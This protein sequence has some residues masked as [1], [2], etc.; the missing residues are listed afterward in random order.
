MHREYDSS[1]KTTDLAMRPSFCLDEANDRSHLHHTGKIFH[2]ICAYLREHA[3]QGS[4]YSH[5]F[6]FAY[7]A[8]KYK[9]CPD[10][11]GYRYSLALARRLSFDSRPTPRLIVIISAIWFILQSLLHLEMGSLSPMGIPPTNPDGCRHGLHFYRTKM[12]SAKRLPSP[13]LPDFHRTCY[14]YYQLERI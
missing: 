10:R 7:F 11:P 14:H 5:N 9:R 1:A 3:R 13:A 4:V 6:F 8:G 2:K 12:L